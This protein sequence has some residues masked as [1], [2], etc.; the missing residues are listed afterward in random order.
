MIQ[1]P[2][3]SQIGHL[4]VTLGTFGKW[5]AITH[6]LSVC[7]QPVFLPISM[8][9]MMKKKET[10]IR[11]VIEPTYLTLIIAFE[12]LTESGGKL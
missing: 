2:L 10:K 11:V 7:P 9:L 1:R 8:S 3:L 6:G 5:D 4:T 12:G